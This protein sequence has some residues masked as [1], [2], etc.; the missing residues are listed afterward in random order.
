[1]LGTSIEFGVMKRGHLNVTDELPPE[2]MIENAHRLIAFGVSTGKIQENYT[3][4]GHRQV[5]DTSCPGNKLFKEI[6]TWKHF[7]ALQRVHANDHI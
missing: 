7:E 5:R 2:H 6:S 3:L 1:M 4:L